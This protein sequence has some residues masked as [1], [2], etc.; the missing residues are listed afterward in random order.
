MKIKKIEVFSTHEPYKRPIPIAVGTHDSRE[1][2][3]VKITADNGLSGW[4]EGSPLLPSYSGEVRDQMVDDIVKR[5]A[6]DILEQNVSNVADI[7]KLIDKIYHNKYYFMCAIA[8]VD[9]AL[10]DLLG[11]LKK[12]PVFE[13]IRDYLKLKKFKKIP[14]LPANFTVSRNATKNDDK[15][16]EMIEEAEK[17]ID[18][19]FMVIKVKIGVFRKSDVKSIV[20]LHNHIKKKYPNRIVYLFADGNQVYKDVNDIYKVLKKIAKYITCIEQPFHRNMPHL[21][22]LL[23][24]KIKNEKGMPLVI[25]DEGNSSIEETE[26]ILISDAAGGCLL[27][28]VRSGGFHY[29]IKLMSLLEKY[30]YFKLGPC[31]MT[32]TGIGTTANLHSALV[33]YDY[34]HRKLGFG[35]DGPMQVIGDDYKK[36]KDTIIYKD[37]DNGWFIKNNKGTGLYDPKQIIGDG[38][39]LGMNLNLGY[40]K[41]ITDLKTT[42]YLKNGNLIKEEINFRN[43][44]KTKQV[45]GK[46]KEILRHPRY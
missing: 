24:K 14:D 23:Y 9:I 16:D 40:I 37:N 11:K 6:P 25:T 45:L 8:A 41:K 5:I 13:L 22:R 26:N 27:K 29:I 20:E 7:L 1:N 42:L 38:K 12:K 4:G 17:Y 33:V 35:F 44:K 43:N 31:S 19:G 39:G 32:E 36:G 18:M 2:V 3:L 21:S 30:P 28:M 15:I 46:Q 10:F 34:C